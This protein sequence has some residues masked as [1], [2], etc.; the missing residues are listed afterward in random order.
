MRRA[1]RQR[2]D[3]TDVR[4]DRRLRADEELA[5]LPERRDVR[6]TAQLLGALARRDDP[7][8]LAV[9]LA[10]EGHGA[11][12][13]RVGE[14][15]DVGRHGGVVEDLPHDEVLDALEVLGGQRGVVVEVKAQHVRRHERALLAQLRPE[16]LA[17]RPLQQVRRGVAAA[18]RGA[19]PAVDREVHRVTGL[20]RA[21]RQLHRMHDEPGRRRL[22]V[23]D[24]PP[25]PGRRDL[26][27]VPHLAAGLGVERRAVAD[28]R[29]AVAA[30]DRLDGD[31]RRVGL[32]V[33]V[34][35]ELDGIEVG[36]AREQPRLERG[37]RPRLEL[38]RAPA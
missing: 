9:A 20:E 12:R 2:L 6:A 16:R 29:H 31:D 15:H 11:E 33:V 34:A 4:A 21:R 24:P 17:Q 32:E 26:A 5:D 23:D 13:L 10:E 18:Q 36:G 38:G 3:A 19:P 37:A 30:L 22:R 7:H 14:R 28:D 35:E 27:R 1:A 8:A 25:C